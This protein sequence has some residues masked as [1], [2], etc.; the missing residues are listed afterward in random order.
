MLQVQRI[1]AEDSRPECTHLRGLSEGTEK[2]KKT[3]HGGDKAEGKVHHLYKAG[4]VGEEGTLHGG[5][6][7][8]Q[9]SL[10][11]VRQGNRGPSMKGTGDLS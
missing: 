8:G 4:K 10:V 3:L 11:G 2:G 9:G 1:S 5:G 7:Q 6:Q